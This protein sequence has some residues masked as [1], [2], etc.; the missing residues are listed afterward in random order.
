MILVR[1]LVMSS[2]L[3][4]VSPLWIQSKWQLVEQNELTPSVFDLSLQAIQLTGY[5]P[6][7]PGKIE[8]EAQK[9]V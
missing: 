7:A 2:R 4:S 8:L 5:P 3:A 9:L 6:F 1:V